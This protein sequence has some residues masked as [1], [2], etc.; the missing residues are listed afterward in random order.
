M[1]GKLKIVLFDPMPIEFRRKI[2]PFD[3]RQSLFDG[4]PYR[5]GGFAQTNIADPP[6]APRVALENCDDFIAQRRRLGCA[7][8]IEPQQVFEQKPQVEWICARDEARLVT[9]AENEHRGGIVAVEI[10][11]I[12]HIAVHPAGGTK[13]A[14]VGIDHER[15]Q[16]LLTE[17]SFDFFDA[18]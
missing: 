3:V 2:D 8:V 7:N 15:F 18:S 14:A 6:P 11:E 10:G 5:Y 13:R 9:G 17:S 4:G 16:A 12:A 1:E